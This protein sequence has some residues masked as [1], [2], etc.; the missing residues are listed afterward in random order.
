MTFILFWY[1]PSVIV[2]VTRIWRILQ[3][4]EDLTLRVSDCEELVGINQETKY[5]T[6]SEA[7]VWDTNLEQIQMK[8]R[9]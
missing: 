6:L 8:R 1:F 5:Y 3:E 7:N 2:C 9:S 4:Y